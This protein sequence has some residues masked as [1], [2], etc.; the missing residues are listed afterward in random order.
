[1]ARSLTVLLPVVNAQSTLTAAVH[2]ALEVFSE[3]SERLEL[4]IVDDGSDDATGEVAQELSR[5]YPQVRSIAHAAQLGREE[6]IRSGLRQTRG[7]VVLVREETGGMAPDEI[8]RWWR[9]AEHHEPLST[10]GARPSTWR[11]VHAAAPSGPARPGYRVFR[12][13]HSAPPMASRPG[14]PNY[15]ARLKS[16]ALGE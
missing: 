10:E 9:A 16:F 4:V 13:T 6:A 2:E 8:A 11:S 7:E 3:L 12:R 5:V 1:M 15:L 14:R